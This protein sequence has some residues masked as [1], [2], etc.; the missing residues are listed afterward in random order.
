MLLLLLSCVRS[1]D[2][3]PIVTSPAIQ[4][5]LVDFVSFIGDDRLELM[6]VDHVE[7]V[8]TAQGMS[9]TVLEDPNCTECFR[10]ERQGEDYTIYGGLPLGVQYGL[11]SLLEDLGYRFWHPNSTYIPATLAPV[12]VDSSPKA[13]KMKRRGIHLHTLH[14]IEGLEAMWQQ[15]D[16]SRARHIMDWVIKNGGNHLQWVA[17]D[18]I[19]NDSGRRTAW[20]TITRD[21]LSYAHGRGLTAGLGIQLFGSGNLQLAFDLVDSPGVDE[22]SQIRSRLQMITE[23]L[24]WDVLN[25]SFGEF[26]GADPEKFIASTN[27]AYAEM[28]AQLPGVD[29]PATIHVGNFED[30]RVTYQ[31]QE[32]LYYFLVQFADPGI[33]P[34]I[35]S[36]MY[37]NL[38]DDAGGAYLHE[39]FDEH[40]T[41]LLDHL[42]ADQPVGYFP[43]SAYWVAFDNPIPLYLPVYLKS[44]HIDFTEIEAAAPGKLQDHVLFSSGWEWGYWQQDI[45]TLRYAWGKDPA[46]DDS[47]RFYFSPLGEAGTQTAQAAI[48]LGELQYTALIEKRLAPWMAGRDAVMDI[49]D[50]AGILSQPRR[51]T[52]DEL[53]ALDAEGLSNWETNVLG[54]LREHAA[55]CA[56]IPRPEVGAETNPVALRAIHEV[57]DGLDVDT[58]RAKFAASLWTSVKVKAE[59]G[60]PLPDIL[61]AEAEL[62][63]ARS[64]VARRH[65]DFHDPNPL[66]TAESWDNATIYDY[67]YL[68]QSHQL[69]FWERERVQ[70]R[71]KLLGE[72]GGIPTCVL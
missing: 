35:H 70:V 59:G 61:A 69:C 33:R 18:D 72:S 16:P 45:A 71:N 66:W 60:D 54:P 26:S 37:Y 38:F 68:A 28:Q 56:A 13:P 48:A 20:Q 55:A 52:L 9:I 2:G 62:E 53:L 43:E 32:L 17:L 12:E 25:L 6:A 44:R 5:V 27:L 58:S 41:F 46:W 36:V 30:L 63:V 51:P 1:Y 14:P 64:I 19:I 40:R 42:K 34:W 31:G 11:A 29:V 8:Q 7:P 67:G 23:D 49:G 4:P 39:E 50:S 65:A 3:L 47:L 21:H 22:A 57:Q 15:E 10:V 24:P